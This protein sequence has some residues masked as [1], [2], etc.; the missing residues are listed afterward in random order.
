MWER[1]EICSG[2]RHEV[3]NELCKSCTKFCRVPFHLLNAQQLPTYVQEKLQH[4]STVLGTPETI[5]IANCF[6]TSPQ[7]P[8]IPRLSPA[9][10][11]RVSSGHQPP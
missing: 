3:L 4:M 7:E 10:L 9:C 6:N 8:W 2:Q 11:S 5:H 1:T